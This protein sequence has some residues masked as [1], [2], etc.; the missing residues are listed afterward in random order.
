VRLADEFFLIAWDTAGSG[1]PLLRVQALSLGLAGALLGE[2]TLEGRIA[3]RGAEVRVADARPLD[4]AVAQSV[5]KEMISAPEH[6]DI[7]TW[8]AYLAKN[9][10]PAVAGR[11]IQSGLLEP[12]ESRVLWRKQVRYSATSFAKGA[13]PAV[14]V[15]RMLVSGQRMT[16]ADMTLA[17]LLEGTGLLDVIIIDRRDRPAARNYFATLMATTPYPLRD[18]AGHVQSAV[19]DAVLSYRS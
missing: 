18:L 16:L 11:L 4:D 9:S 17:A 12:R 14:R 8:L 3:V 15:E 5:L 1:A 10:V 7:R 2:L 6:D 13:W 19:G